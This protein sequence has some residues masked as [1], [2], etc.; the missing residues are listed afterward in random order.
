MDEQPENLRTYVID[1]PHCGTRLRLYAEPGIRR[2]FI[3]VNCGKSFAAS[4]PKRGKRARVR[5]RVIDPTDP[6]TWPASRRVYEVTDSTDAE[7]PLYTPSVRRAVEWFA[8]IEHGSL[9]AC[10]V[11][12]DLRDAALYV[13]LL[14]GVGW[15]ESSVDLQEKK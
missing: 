7:H 1:C 13:A 4:T 11:R 15:A 12:D 5:G 14:S 6:R 2:D 10:L 9:R 3:C 8:E